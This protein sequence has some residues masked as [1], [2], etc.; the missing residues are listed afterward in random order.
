MNALPEEHP[1]NPFAA[2]CHRC[3]FTYEPLQ[4]AWCECEGAAR[5]LICPEC[6]HCFCDAPV[7]YRRLFWSSVPA[8]LRQ[9]P[10]RFA[11]DK[12][13]FPTH[14]NVRAVA[15]NAPVVVIVDDDEAVRSLV[16]CYVESLGYRTRLT[17]DPFEALELAQARDVR[18]LITD[19]LMP[20]MDGRELCRSL[21]RTR[22]GLLKKAIVM[23]SLYTARRFRTEAFQ[24]FGVDEYLSKPLNLPLLGT[25]LTRFAPLP[26]P[27]R[28]SDVC[29][30][31][32]RGS[33]PVHIG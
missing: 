27:A 16:A 28:E 8:Q 5:S 1:S 12:T 4:A 10:R 22:P 25:I 32:K 23:T 17:D 20:R 31:F 14:A 11:A 6:G 9:D 33:R 7:A 2:K 18:V 26:P 13:G 19:A 15:L 30:D 3:A 21:K 29:S 24:Q